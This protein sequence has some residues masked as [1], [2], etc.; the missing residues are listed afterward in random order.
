MNQDIV[1]LDI[2]ATHRYLNVVGACLTAILERLE[3]LAEPE[4]TTYNIVLAVH[5]ICTNVVTHA[6]AGQSAGRIE[7]T[8]A[9]TEAPRRLTVELRDAGRPFQPADIPTPN[10]QQPQE[11]GYGLFLAQT[12]MDE[13]FYEANPKGNYWRLT[14]AI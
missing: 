13:V 5:E 4:A 2:P 3:G 1:R 11:H 10:L 8:L 7:I 14:K 9:L 6:Y 12:L